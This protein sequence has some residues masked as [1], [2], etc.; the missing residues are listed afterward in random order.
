MVW[1]GSIN[2]AK[3][4]AMELAAQLLFSRLKEMEQK[5]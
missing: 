5:A 3:Q 1:G 4:P 2:V